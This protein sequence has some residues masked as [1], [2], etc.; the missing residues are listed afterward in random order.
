MIKQD[1]FQDWWYEPAEPYPVKD[2]IKAHSQSGSFTKNWW[3]RRWIQSLT[4]L[5]DSSRLSRGKQYARAGQ[6]ISI[7]VNP[8]LILAQVQGTR[9]QPYRQRIEIR[10]FTASEWERALAYLASQAL[11]S[12]QL[13]NGEM[14]QNIEEAFAR[15]GLN[16][17]PATANELVMSCTCPDWARPCKHLAA[18]LLLV[19]ESLD[20]DP[21]LLFVMRGRNRDQIMSAL[22]DRR[23]AL[24]AGDLREATASGRDREAGQAAAETLEERASRFWK[25]GDAG[26]VPI[27]VQAPEVE[28]E[29]IKLLGIPSFL[30]DEALLAELSQV[31]RRVTAK[32]L[33][34]AYASGEHPERPPEAG[35][36]VLKPDNEPVK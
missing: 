10:E 27:H 15:A 28:M 30:E 34:V 17:F 35:D 16:L 22:R 4:Q 36:A 14:P 32:A 1:D 33:D 31:Y 3:A 26:P 6:V 25:M 20:D 11:F 5:M 9:P 24:A 18:V 21:F 19:G 23:A 13:L 2:G 29:L 7:E 12:A 8:G